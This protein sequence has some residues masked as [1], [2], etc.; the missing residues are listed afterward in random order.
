MNKGSLFTIFLWMVL[1]VIM[2][3]GQICGVTPFFVICN[4]LFCFINGIVLI[5]LIPLVISEI[6]NRKKAKCVTVEEKEQ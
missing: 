4:D 1:A 3:V 5:A 2:I 6:K